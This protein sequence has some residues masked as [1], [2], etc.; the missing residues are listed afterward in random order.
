MKYNTPHINKVIPIEIEN[1]LSS[2]IVNEDF[3]IESTGQ[4]VIT[5]DF[6]KESFNHKWE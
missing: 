6:T 2:S 3:S 5:Y 4:E 1:L